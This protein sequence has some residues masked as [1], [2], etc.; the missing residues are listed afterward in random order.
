MVGRGNKE[1]ARQ[2]H[3][4]RGYGGMKASSP[5]RRLGDLIAVDMAKEAGGAHRF[6]DHCE[7]ILP[8]GHDS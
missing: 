4:V 2:E 6:A 5:G 7:S 1:V 3:G 8:A